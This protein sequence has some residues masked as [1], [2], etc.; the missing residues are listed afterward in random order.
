[1]SGPCK[2]RGTVYPDRY[3]LPAITRHVLE[4]LERRRPALARWDDEARAHLE[5]EAKTALAAVKQQF[6]EIA[7]DPVYWNQLERSFFEVALP[8]YFRLAQAQADL[9]AKKY[10]LWRGGDFLSRLAYAG[11]G[12]ALAVVLWR[13]PELPKWLEPLPLLLFVFGPL[14]PDLQISAHRRRY[15]RALVD[16]VAEMSEEAV[17]QQAYPALSA[18]ID[19]LGSQASSSRT[20]EKA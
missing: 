19:D 14:I 5:Q 3:R 13:V 2:T 4:L 8:R 6:A 11:L 1:M 18:P 20:K 7:D 17:Q 9:E 12:L 16:L 10:E 15:R